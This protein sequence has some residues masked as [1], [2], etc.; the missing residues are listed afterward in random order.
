MIKRK[1]LL[2]ICGV[3]LVCA[4]SL[5][6]CS[7]DAPENADTETKALTTV[8]TTP[9]A[10][11]APPTTAGT[12]AADTD[13]AELTLPLS[14]EAADIL[15]ASEFPGRIIVKTE[16][17]GEGYYIFH[18]AYGGQDRICAVC[19]INKGT[20]EILRPNIDRDYF[21]DSYAELRAG[22]LIFTRRWSEGDDVGMPEKAFVFWNNSSQLSVSEVSAYLPMAADGYIIQSLTVTEPSLLK[23][24]S[25][26]DSLSLYFTNAGDLHFAAPVPRT[27]FEYDAQAGTLVIFMDLPIELQAKT[28]DLGISNTFINSAKLEKTD[29]GAKI[30]LKLTEFAQLYRC[31]VD[32][33]YYPEY[34]L[35]MFHKIPRL[36]VGFDFERIDEAVT[37]P[38]AIIPFE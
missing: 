12:T 11:T 28:G 8:G 18:K 25:N 1:S 23:V 37:D 26:Y 21:I 34:A 27:H 9:A 38:G 33:V 17:V 36:T 10:S 31:E 19:C 24:E 15:F 6:G 35:G 2:C 5:S 16:T 30:T 22:I 29:C 4:V 13:P 7:G 20:G 32:E 3:L 14:A